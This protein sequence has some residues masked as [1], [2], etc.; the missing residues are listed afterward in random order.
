MGLP[1]TLNEADCEVLVNGFTVLLIA[2]VFCGPARA[3]IE[4][5]DVTGGRIKGEIVENVAV[6]KGIPFAAQPVGAL[7]WQTPQP[8]IAWTG[9]RAATTF[10]PACMQQPWYPNA[11]S[12]PSEDCLYLNVWTAAASSAERRPV[13]VWIHGGGLRQGMSWERLSYGNKL[14]PEGLVL[15]SIAYRLG[16]FGFLAHPDLTREKGNGSGNYGLFDSLAALRWVKANITQFGGDPARV[17][18]MGG[19]SGALTVG[20]LAAAPQAKGLFSRA[21]AVGGSAFY[22]RLNE[23]LV[24]TTARYSLRGAEET[25]RQLFKSLGV[26]NLKAARAIPAQKLLAVAQS[27][28]LEFGV[29]FDGDLVQRPNTELYAQGQFNDTPILVGFTSAEAGEAP[30]ETSVKWLQAEMARRLPCPETHAAIFAAY[31]FATDEQAKLAHRAWQRD[32]WDGWPTWTWARLQSAKGLNRAYVYYFDV[33]DDEHPFGAP[34]AAEYPYLFGNFPKPHTAHD[35]ALSTLIRKY[36]VNFATSGDPNGPGLPA[37]KPFDAESSSAMVF[38][39]SASSQR[40]PDA[41]GIKAL[42][43]SLRCGMR[44]H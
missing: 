17:T 37:W 8:V 23:D 14:A 41:D 35:E 43:A 42:D 10:A 7:R 28:N 9:V 6:F 36:L 19:S 24:Q 12:Q 2:A 33:H 1:L 5:A 31:P 32:L 4:Y 21:V 13:M 27:T 38:A 34:H 26:V 20:L 44:M 15:V 30:P 29:I 18:I 40:M 39:A 3:A 16:P 11:P 25:G 22:P